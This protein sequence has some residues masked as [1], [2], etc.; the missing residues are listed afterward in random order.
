MNPKVRLYLISAL[1]PCVACASTSVNVYEPGKEK[2]TVIK[3]R[4]GPIETIKGLLWLNNELFWIDGDNYFHLDIQT[5]NKHN[6]I[7]VYLMRSEKEKILL[8]RTLPI[9]GVSFMGGIPQSFEGSLIFIQPETNQ[10]KYRIGLSDIDWKLVDS[11]MGPENKPYK[12]YRGTIK[13][14][15]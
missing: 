10:I 2:R 7:H 3:Y 8:G 15:P 14:N 9:L 12:K 6:D 13:Y 5:D 1:L 4:T 11:G